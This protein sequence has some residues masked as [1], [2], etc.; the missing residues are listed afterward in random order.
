VARY[1]FSVE[2]SKLVRANNT[3]L[4]RAG[5]RATTVAAVATASFL[6]LAC[7][8]AIDLGTG[9]AVGGALVAK[10]GVMAIPV[11]VGLYAWRRSPANRM[12]PLLILM[13][14]VVA[15]G[16]LSASENDV[17]YSIGRLFVWLGEAAVL[18]VI[19]ASPAGRLQARGERRV[20]AALVG[21]LFVFYL[22]TALV[23]EQFPSPVPWSDC[24]TGCPANAFA[25]AAQEPAFIEDVIVPLRGALTVVLWMLAIG[26]VALRVRNASALTRAT[27]LPLLGV[28]ALRVVTFAA[29]LPVRDSGPDSTVA[30]ALGWILLLTVPLIAL[31]FLVGRLEWR[32]HTASVLEDLTKR[33]R[34]IAGA[35]QL[36][37]AL[38]GALADPLL[39]VARRDP[40]S[41][42]G[43]VDSAHNV[44]PLPRAEEG[45]SLL[46]VPADRSF[47]AISYDAD[48]DDHREL[49]DAMRASAL[50][51]LEREQMTEALR[52]SMTELERSRA[53]IAAAADEERRRIER[54]L[55]DGAQ[56]G[57]VTLRIKLQLAAEMLEREPK[58]GRERVEALGAEIEQ[59]LEQVRAL[60]QGI[61]PPLLMDAGL[62]QALRA[63][64]GSSVVPITVSADNLERY[65]PQVEGA[66]YFTC[67]EALQNA[68]KH[69]GAS[70]MWISLSE[71]GSLEFEI[72]DDGDGMPE[73]GAGRGRGMTNMRD[74]LAAVGGTLEVRSVDGHGTAVVGTVPLSRAGDRQV[75]RLEG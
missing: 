60:G 14:C 40:G 63:A 69:A 57:L 53:R 42:T 45:R 9:G 41:P 61:Y 74:R 33:M 29:Y 2:A 13:G 44:V 23:V 55:H 38:R 20:F 5:A 11:L 68:N 39:K 4:D 8:V 62:E 24:T 19:L 75:T 16:G 66:V 12:G 7:V 50:A 70:R 3:Y 26:F 27:L 30:E 25:L 46:Y 15:L 36:E 64:A 37:G 54:D 65:S 67:L 32:L 48:L 49:V 58:A 6:L 51:M 1:K 21:V 52:S 72:G 31:A 10:V 71:N 22:P 17:A 18:Y 43:W 47:V 56:Q 35:D 34:T 73:N 28:A 59:I